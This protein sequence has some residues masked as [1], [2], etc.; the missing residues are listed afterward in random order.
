MVLNYGNIEVYPPYFKYH[1]Q[2]DI[3]I[4]SKTLN[5]KM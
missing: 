3:R 1:T 4:R 5:S 2:Q